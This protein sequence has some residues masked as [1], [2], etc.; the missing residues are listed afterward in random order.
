MTKDSEITTSRPLPS[1]LM[2]ASATLKLYGNI[3][4]WVQLVL[5]IVAFI[6]LL[7]AST[8]LFNEKQATPG[9][10]FGFFCAIAGVVALGV[11]ILCC[12]RYRKIAQMMQ[13][14]DP[15]ERPKKGYTLQV[16]KFGLIANLVGMFLAIIGAEALVGLLLGKL[17]NLPQGAA[18]YD[19]SQLPQPKEIVIILANTHTIMSHFMGISISLW[20]LNRLNR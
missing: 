12:F 2:R 10:G 18:V 19:T 5:G 20:L 13:A 17:L 7:F 14:P 4:F 3:G 16:I 15:V 11:S 9:I 8:S 6:I 1:G